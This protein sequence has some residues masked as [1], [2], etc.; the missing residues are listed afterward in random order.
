MRWLVQKAQWLEQ[1][2][3][4]FNTQTPFMTNM[5]VDDRDIVLQAAQET[6]YKIK[7]SSVATDMLGNALPDTIS[8]YALETREHGPFWQRVRA[9]RQAKTTGGPHVPH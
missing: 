4:M 9:L 7:V 3:L 8:V 1:E 2:A 6:G 5:S